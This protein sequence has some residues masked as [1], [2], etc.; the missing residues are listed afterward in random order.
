MVKGNFPREQQELLKLWQLIQQTRD[1]RSEFDLSALFKDYPSDGISKPKKDSH[2]TPTL[3]IKEEPFKGHP[4]SLWKSSRLAQ[5]LHLQQS[6]GQRHKTF[7]E[8]CNQLFPPKT[9][10]SKNNIHYGKVADQ[11]RFITKL[12]SSNP[13]E[14]QSAL[15]ELLQGGPIPPEVLHKLVE[16]IEK[17]GIKVPVHDPEWLS[18]VWQYIDT[19][20][21]SPY[22]TNLQPVSDSEKP[23]IDRFYDLSQPQPVQPAFIQL[24]GI[25]DCCAFSPDG[26]QVL[27]GSIDGILRL[28]NRETG[29]TIQTFTGH[30]GGVMSCAFSPDGEEV[31]SGSDDG[32][33][34]LWNVADGRCVRISYARSLGRLADLVYINQRKDKAKGEVLSKGEVLLRIQLKPRI[35]VKPEELKNLPAPNF[36][37]QDQ[38]LSLYQPRRV[39]SIAAVL[40]QFG[41]EE[42][43][44][45]I[46]YLPESWKD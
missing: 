41:D 39:W 21:F 27:T 29:E 34:R 18:I 12:L 44:S 22:I 26:K 16:K 9:S 10:E 28:W 2:V 32:T 43:K 3:P 46:E 38:V 37:F 31:L 40:Q 35:H 25:S 1:Q 24:Y 7:E 19:S 17:E 6:L 13:T 4:N 5:M 8:Y 30:K 36:I 23:I 45:Y 42:T 15:T 14:W 20:G 33:L 11:D